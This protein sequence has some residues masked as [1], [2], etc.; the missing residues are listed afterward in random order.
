MVT[1][2]DMRLNLKWT[3]ERLAHEAGVSVKTVARWERNSPPKVVVKWL[4]TKEEC[5][6]GKSGILQKGNF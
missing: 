3:Q 1:L 6:F 5:R 4:K 2:R